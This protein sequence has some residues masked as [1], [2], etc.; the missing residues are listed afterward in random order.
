M[1][2]DSIYLQYYFYTSTVERAKHSTDDTSHSLGGSLQWM[3]PG[4]PRFGQGDKKT[5]ASQ[6][7]TQHFELYS[8]IFAAIRLLQH[9]YYT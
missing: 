1:G 3:T 6:K 7:Q 4:A 9:N 8:L 5:V 2:S